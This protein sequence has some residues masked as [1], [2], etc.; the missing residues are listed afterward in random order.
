M[1][2]ALR[3]FILAGMH[4]FV[5]VRVVCHQVTSLLPLSQKYNKAVFNE[6]LNHSRE[7]SFVT[8]NIL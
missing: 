6:L 8:E 1:N 2:V 4:T 5:M 7:F 3:K